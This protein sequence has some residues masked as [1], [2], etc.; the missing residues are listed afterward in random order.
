[1]GGSRV[2]YWCADGLCPV[3]SDQARSSMAVGLGFYWGRIVLRRQ[4]GKHVWS[5]A[6]R[7]IHRCG[8]RVFTGPYGYPGNGLCGLD[9]RQGIQFLCDR[10]SVHENNA[11]RA[12]ERVLDLQS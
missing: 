10:F 3:L 12:F 7:S 9:H 5:A 8:Y 2:Q 6:Q 4:P 1:M 11:E